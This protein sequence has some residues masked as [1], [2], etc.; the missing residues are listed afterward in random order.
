ML[1][2]RTDRLAEIVNIL[3]KYN[4]QPKRIRIVYP[5][6]KE[7]SNLVLIDAKKNGKVGLK[8]LEPL[9]CHNCDGSYTEEINRM[10]ER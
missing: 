5:K 4:L 3:T 7:N 6:T 10:L 2:H 1:V 8:V 9:I